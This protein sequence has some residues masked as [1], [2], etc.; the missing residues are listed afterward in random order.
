MVRSMR[1]NI[2]KSFEGIDTKKQLHGLHRADARNLETF[3]S[4]KT[5]HRLEGSL[6]DTVIT[7]PPYADQKDYGYDEDLQVGMG[8]SYSEYLEELRTVFKQTYDLTKPTGTLWVVSNTF[9]RDGRTV[10]LPF[11]IAD[12]CENLHNR[13]ECEECESRLDRQRSTRTLVCPDCGWEHDPLADSWILQD[14]IVWDKVRARPWSSKGSM[15]NVFEYVLCFSKSTDFTYDLD[16]IRIAD[17][18]EFKQWWVDYP[19]RYNPRGK[20][21]DNVWTMLTPNQGAY[22]DGTIDHPAPFPP[23]LVERII[24][25]TTTPD[26]IVFDPFAGTGTVLAKADVMDRVPIGLELSA[27]YISAYPKLRETIQ[28]RHGDDESSIKEKQARCMN[29]LCGLREIRYAR[30]LI[31]MTR[32]QLDNPSLADLGIKS[33]LNFSKGPIQSEPELD[34]HYVEGEYLVLT[35][36]NTDV[37]QDVDQALI[38]AKN[39]NPCSTFGIDATLQIVPIDHL[40]TLGEDWADTTLFLYTDDTQHKYSEQLTIG[41]FTE[42]VAKPDWRERTAKRQHPGIL[43]NIGLTVTKPSAEGRGRN[44][45]HVVERTYTNREKSRIIID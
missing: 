33:V 23:K 45:T 27:E 26:D 41:K 7:S 6:F 15:R 10:Q 28:A 20:V 8:D 25:L 12:V 44:E 4:Q 31:R 37:S 39:K 30:E 32:K 34:R 42:E 35:E 36:A 29:L 14:I 38:N 22:G 24:R 2:R 17:P 16:A 11:D 9:K 13:T 40:E 3:L 5:K 18:D 1:S 21:P 43:S 19:H